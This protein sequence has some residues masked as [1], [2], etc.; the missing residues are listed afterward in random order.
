MFDERSLTT[1]GATLA[2]T[3]RNLARQARLVLDFPSD[4]A[5]TRELFDAIEELERRIEPG[6]S[7]DLGRWLASLRRRVEGRLPTT[8]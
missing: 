3:V 6:T 7:K 2:R 4:E 8:V 1:D 5:E